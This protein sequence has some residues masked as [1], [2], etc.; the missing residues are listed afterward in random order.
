[1]SKY[2]HQRVTKRKKKLQQDHRQ[3]WADQSAWTNNYANNYEN[4]Y[5]NNY[6][7]G[8]GSA[9]YDPYQQQYNHEL[10]ALK[11]LNES[12]LYD[13]VYNYLN[14]PFPD[15]LEKKVGQGGEEGQ[16]NIFGP[17]EPTVQA[18]KE[19]TLVTI[20]APQ[21]LYELIEIIDKYPVKDDV[22]YNIDLKSLSN[23][24]SELVELK[25]MIGLEKIKESVF[26]QLI[27]FIQNLHTSTNAGA[28]DS[29]GV[30][31]STDYKHTVIM[32]PPGAGKTQIA[33]IIG[34]MYSKLGILSNNVFKKV[35]RNDLIAGY[36]GQTAIK[37]SKVIED[38]LGGVLFIDEAYSLA[39]EDK[40]DMFS[41]ECLDTLCEALSDH[42][43]N[44][45]VIIA[46][47]ENELNNRFFTA[48]SGL[49]SRFI[50][51]FKTETYSPKEL[52]QIFF[53]LVR[54]RGWTLVETVDD[55]PLNIQNRTPLGG[56]VQCSMATLP[57]NQLKGNPPKVDCPISNVHG[58]KTWE[59][60]FH[61][62]KDKFHGLG[63]DMEAL[64]TYVKI[65]HGV[66]VF[67]KGKEVQKKISLDDMNRGYKTFLDNLHKKEE[68]LSFMNS[69]YI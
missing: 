63:R 11:L 25:D 52:M 18:I 16:S 39:N 49:E 3:W 55:T 34:K 10:A 38:C 60:W 20:D 6:G 28:D 33:K 50:W 26:E 23:I 64:F 46:G 65:G 17:H 44:L 41:K 14:Y 7:G 22:E 51:K 13:Q 68:G 59:K 8:Y 31:T 2:Y 12:Y 62:K 32:G 57:V 4:N 61:E 40:E 45:M 36:L 53:R 19:K 27:Y 47:Y 67:G 29:K 42:K 58:C 56:P 48:N 1:M 54:S 30:T 43:D 35:T 21:N 37:T 69:I 24:R 9:Y 5:A 66:R 15:V